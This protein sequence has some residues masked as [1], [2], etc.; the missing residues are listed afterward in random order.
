MQAKPYLLAKTYEGIVDRGLQNNYN[1]RSMSLVASLA[2][3]CI[4][5]DSK[6]RPTM[7]QVLRELEEALQYEDRPE[8]TLASPSQPDSAA[9]DFKSTAS[10][11]PPDSAPQLANVPSFTF[12]R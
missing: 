12:P 4:E 11:T 6:N 2:L 10:D 7:L 1:S 9:F 3:R 8:R 5:R